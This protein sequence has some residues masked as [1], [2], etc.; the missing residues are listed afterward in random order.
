M[1]DANTMEKNIV[2]DQHAGL[3]SEGLVC[4]AN[5]S[6]V[7]DSLIKEPDNLY[8]FQ[9]KGRNLGIVML[10][11]TSVI[12]GIAFV[13]QS[14]GMDHVGPMEFVAYRFLLASVVF[15]PV[16]WFRLKK[17]RGMRIRDDITLG[18]SELIRVS[19]VSGLKIGGILFLGI[20]LQQIGLQYTT[21]GKAGFISTLYIVIV[22]FLGFWYGKALRGNEITSAVLAIIGMFL[23]SIHEDFSIGLGDG[24]MVISAMMFSFQILAID[25]MTKNTDSI[26]MASSQYLV[27]GVL[28]LIATLIFEKPDLRGFADAF[29]PI[30]YAAIL[31]TCLSYTF[32]IIGQKYVEPNIASMIM[33]LEAVFAAL[34]GFLILGQTLRSREIIGCVVVFIAIVYAQKQ[35]ETS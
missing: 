4:D 14:V 35:E 10:L 33:S 18:S 29:I 27:V 9:K 30:A 24:L 11:I 1:G 23:L 15:I 21:V 8:P 13:A 34:S 6:S 7:S 19:F 12:W 20:V 3:A 28:A 17:V 5:R 16:V 26:I 2:K 25:K 32:Q 31:S 22:P